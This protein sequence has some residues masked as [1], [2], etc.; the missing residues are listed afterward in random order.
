MNDFS[1]DNLTVN[2][3][4]MVGTNLTVA[5]S[6]GVL[7]FAG[8]GTSAAGGYGIYR[9]GNGHLVFQGGY[10]GYLF[11]K[12]DATKI[13]GRVSDT[14]A[15]DFWD[16]GSGAAV[17]NL[18]S[19][20]AVNLLGLYAA[21]ADGQVRI[22]ALGT[23]SLH[24]GNADYTANQEIVRLTPQGWN[25]NVEIRATGA[26]ANSLG[27]ATLVF[28]ARENAIPGNPPALGL[29]A[30]TASGE[31][32]VNA[33]GWLSLGAG[34][35][36]YVATSEAVRIL[37]GG[38][39]GIGTAVP[40]ARL[41]VGE[42]GATANAP[43]DGRIISAARNTSGTGYRAYEFGASEAWNFGFAIRDAAP[44]GG[45]RLLVNTTGVI[46]AFG[47]VNAQAGLQVKDKIYA[48]EK[49]VNGQ[50]LGRVTTH[51]FYAFKSTGGSTKIA[52]GQGCY[53]A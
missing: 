5:G 14:G 27:A 7:R 36:A 37:P 23:L 30:D 10:A 18:K 51:Q 3:Q 42:A 29:Y 41:Q 38:N 21:S 6:G 19:A 49:T 17:L 16:G 48:Q 33:Q 9:T 22:G 47:R 45:V 13:L 8:N 1:C 53:Y 11:V 46:D 52:D 2:A 31:A 44:D 32:R 28:R 35:A 26:Q 40:G 12:S 39:V 4:A 24:A 15:A 50:V 25:G 43:S 20:T 34:N